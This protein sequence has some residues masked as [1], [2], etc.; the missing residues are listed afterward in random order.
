MKKPICL[1][2]TAI[3]LLLSTIAYSQSTPNPLYPHLPPKAD[4]VYEIDFNQLNAKGNLSAML[5]GIPI[6]GQA[7]VLLT[8]LKDP[9]AAGIDLV[10]LRDLMGHANPE[11]TA[12]YVHLS[13]QTLAA[14][15]ARD[16]QETLLGLRRRMQDGSP[17]SR[18]GETRNPMTQPGGEYSVRAP[19]PDDEE[20]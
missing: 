8:I 7:A 6:K 12:A 13:P 20:A 19:R 11:T 14:E 5:S 1:F 3:T 10:A 4:H 16:K 15:Y 17:A 9:A 18:L 2:F